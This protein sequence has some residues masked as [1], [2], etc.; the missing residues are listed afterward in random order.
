MPLPFIPFELT[1]YSYTHTLL[2]IH[3]IALSYLLIHLIIYFYSFLLL[4]P[5]PPPSCGYRLC[6]GVVV[7]VMPLITA[8][9]A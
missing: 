4:L 3:L 1:S 6:E 8:Q 2:L 7:F 9:F 5:S